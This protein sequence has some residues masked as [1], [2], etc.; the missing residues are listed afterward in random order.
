MIETAQKYIDSKS[1]SPE[2]KQLDRDVDA[3]KESFR[4]AYSGRRLF[5]TK[6]KYIGIAA[7]SLQPGD[8]LWVLAGAAVPIILRHHL[9]TG[10][11]SL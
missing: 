4:V 5:R 8:T 7:Q 6:R 3:I 2:K 9:P 11:G 1:E 10:I